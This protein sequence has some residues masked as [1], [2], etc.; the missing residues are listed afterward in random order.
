[1]SEKY[2]KS[3]ESSDKAATTAAAGSSLDELKAFFAMSNAL[4]IQWMQSVERMATAAIAA[5]QAMLASVLKGAEN[6]DEGKFTVMVNA[7]KEV[8]MAS[9]AAEQAVAL[10]GAENGKAF[11]KMLES[12]GSKS[13]ETAAP[14]LSARVTSLDAQAQAEL[15]VAQ[16]RSE[17]AKVKAYNAETERV[18]AE[19]A[20]AQA[21]A[22]QQNSATEDKKVKVAYTNGVA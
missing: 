4:C 2:M 14:V 12:L 9:I 20:R 16:T 8:A 11:I 3:T 21:K 7:Q 15:L 19:A 5:E 22:N 6:I 18:K 17:E 10:A 1:M 13:I